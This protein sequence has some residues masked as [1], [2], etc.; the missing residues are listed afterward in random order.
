MD[1]RRLTRLGTESSQTDVEC[2]EF[3]KALRES[4]QNIL[5]AKL[6]HQTAKSNTSKMSGRKEGMKKRKQFFVYL[7]IFLQ[8]IIFTVFFQCI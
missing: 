5:L 7:F 3:G 4:S 2:L 6:V 1:L 8:E